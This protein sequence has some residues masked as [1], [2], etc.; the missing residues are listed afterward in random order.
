MKQTRDSV[1][2]SYAFCIFT[3]ADAFLPGRFARYFIA[4]R[5]VATPSVVPGPRSDREFVGSTRPARTVPRHRLS[6]HRYVGRR[7][8][9]INIGISQSKFRRVA[10]SVRLSGDHR[11]VLGGT[12]RGTNSAR[13]RCV[14]SS[15]FTDQ[16][17]FED[18][19][20]PVTEGRERERGGQVAPAP[21]WSR[22]PYERRVSERS[23]GGGVVG[24][25][26]GILKTESL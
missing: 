15:D 14:E 3:F 21:S 24:R 25:I 6:C 19:S 9:S 20:D 17:L 26:T 22:Q 18:V 7:D 12:S 16:L 1:A 4:R 5:F 23:V 2:E 13:K 8:S 10:E 11:P